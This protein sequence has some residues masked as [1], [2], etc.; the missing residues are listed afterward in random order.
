M[1]A[2]TDSRYDACYY[3][4]RPIL[5]G[6]IIEAY[7]SEKPTEDRNRTGKPLVNHRDLVDCLDRRGGQRQ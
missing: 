6:R 3:R 7:G 4:R 1:T 5:L 2:A